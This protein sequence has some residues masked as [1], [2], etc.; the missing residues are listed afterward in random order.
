MEGH[1]ELLGLWLSENEGAK[2]WLSVLTVLKKRGIKDIFVACVD[3]LTGFPDAIGA[4]FPKTQIQLCIVHR[5]RNS[6][7]FV[8]W[9]DR[10]LIAAD[11]KK[12]Y[13]SITVDEAETEL[14]A[15]AKTWDS[16]Y[17]SISQSWRNHW[18]NLIAFF[19]Y[20]NEI[21]K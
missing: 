3:G 14:E 19:A 6:L 7:R 9:K 4:V 16:Q 13:Q 18:P 10:P 21:R 2:F 20:P 1:K 15:F 5:V 11:L 17:P 12:I 8:S